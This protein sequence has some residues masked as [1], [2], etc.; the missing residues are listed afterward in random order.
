[1]NVGHNLVGKL[2]FNSSLAPAMFYF[3]MTSAI[4]LVDSHKDF[5]PEIC[6][7]VYSRVAKD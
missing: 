7:A 4:H 5:F 6:F 3:V 1:M 2:P